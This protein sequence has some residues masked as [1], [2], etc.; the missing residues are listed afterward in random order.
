VKSFEYPV[1]VLFFNRPH[2]VK[3]VLRCLKESKLPLQEEKLVFHLDGFSGS[4]FEELSEKDRTP[5][6]DKLVRNY[7]PKSHVIKQKTNIGIAKSFFEIKEYVFRE[8]DSDFAVFQE[9]DTLLYPSYFEVMSLA[10][11]SLGDLPW[12][13]ALSISNQDHYQNDEKGLIVPTFG[14]REMALNR[15]VFLESKDIYLAYLDSLGGSYRSKNLEKVNQALKTFDLNLQS[16]MQDVFQHEIIRMQKRQQVRINTLGSFQA[17]FSAGESIQGLSIVELLL[18][19]IGKR[20]DEAY[21]MDLQEF[22]GMRAVNV[23]TL[24]VLEDKL[25]NGWWERFVDTSASKPIESKLISIRNMLGLAKLKHVI[26]SML[27]AKEMRR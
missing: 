13:G 16:P 5:A 10:L 17:N 7:F 4:K 27:I 14:T 15:K 24:Q 19:L 18:R 9:E 11:Q 21:P 20:S 3:L 6:V 22:S 25:W 1:G 26:E 23:E 2:L 12:L 8:F